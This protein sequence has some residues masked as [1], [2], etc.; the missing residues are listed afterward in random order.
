MCSTWGVAL[1]VE[2]G[3]LAHAEAVLLVDHRDRQRAE[4]DVRLDQRVR[5]DDHRQLAAR[6]LAEDRPRLAAGVDPVSSAARHG[7]GAEQPLDVREVLLGERLGRRHQG[8]LAAV[9]DGSQH[10]VQRD[11]GLAAAD[12]AHQQ[13]AASGWR[14]PGRR[15][16]PGIARAGRRSGRTAGSRA[17]SAV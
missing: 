9:L 11:D 10:R 13:A 14:A 6:E 15:R 2:R 4:R 5:A 1:R 17:A 3:P 16:S 7:L 8:G 12:L